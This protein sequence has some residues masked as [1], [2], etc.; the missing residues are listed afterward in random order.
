[1][2]VRAVLFDVGDTLW[3]A[4]EAPPPAE[5]RRRAAERAAQFLAANGINGANPAALARTC[6]DAMERAMRTA[7]LTDLVEPDYPAVAAAAARQLGVSLPHDLAAAFLDAIYVSG[8][9]GGKA[10]YPD[11]RATLEALRA[12]GFRLGIVTNRAFGGHRFRADLEEA[13]LDI[14]WDA[15][16]VSVEVGYLKPHPRPFEAALA[17]LN[18][19]PAEAV[20]VGNSLTEDVAGAQRLGIAAAWKRSPA[21]VPGVVPDFV[22]DRVSELLD[23]SLLA[24]AAHV[25]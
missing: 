6:W 20:M 22:F 23:W 9:E 19:A 15:I 13:G 24:E 4:A 5:F 18:L 16:A 21:T 7:R 2:P 10:P 17:A 11:A 25:R 8:A 3:H 14:P 1:M 12:R